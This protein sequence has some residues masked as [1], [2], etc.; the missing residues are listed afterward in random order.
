M[1]FKLTTSDHDNPGTIRRGIS[2]I[3]KEV[4]GVDVVDAEAVTTVT[5]ASPHMTKLMPVPISKPGGTRVRSI[6]PSIQPRN[7]NIGSL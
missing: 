4:L 3:E 6:A 7:P 1:T 5:L 2:S